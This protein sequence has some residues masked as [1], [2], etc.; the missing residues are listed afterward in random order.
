MDAIV[1][2]IDPAKAWKNILAAL[3]EL[4]LSSA[5]SGALDRAT[6]AP[7]RLIANTAWNLWDDFQRNAPTAIDE[8]KKFW[9]QTSA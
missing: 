4:A 8:L 9:V 1:G 3:R 5:K 7:D 2:E 6:V